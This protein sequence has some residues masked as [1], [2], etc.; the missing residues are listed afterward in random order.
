VFEK[1][2]KATARAAVVAAGTALVGAAAVAVSAPASADIGDG[3][4]NC[5]SGE[6]CFYYYSTAIAQGSNPTRHFWN[7][8]PDH[9][10]DTFNNRG[11]S[12]VHFYD[13]ARAGQNR[14]TVCNVYVYDWGSSGFWFYRGGYGNLARQDVNNAHSRC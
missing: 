10:N 13:N 3:S 5:N 4:L 11:L 7:P 2:K 1:L 8:D 12:G 6:I 14:D 9:G